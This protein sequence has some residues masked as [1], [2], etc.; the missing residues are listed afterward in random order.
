[1]EELNPRKVHFVGIGGVGMGSFATALRAA[2]FEVSGSDNALYE[3]MKSVLAK[4]NI[5]LLE[6]FQAENISKVDP[7]LV[8]IGNVVRKDN[9]E[10][11]AWIKKGTKFLSFPEA[12]RTFLIDDKRSI[13]CAGTHGKTT[14]TSWISFLLSGLGLNPSYLIGGVPNDLPSGCLITK[15]D[16]CVVEGD[17]YDS[18]FFDKGPKFLHYYPQIAVISSIEF[19]HADIY[20]D[21]A[22]VKSSFEKLVALLPGDGLF[23]ARYDDPVV[24][25]IIS[26]ALCPV[27]TFGHGSGAMWKLGAVEE[28]IHGFTF[29]IIYKNRSAGTFKTPL[30]GEHNLMNLIS[31]IVCAVNLGIPLEKVR[32]LVEKFTGAVRRQ[33]VLAMEPVRIVD[34]F[35]HHPTEVAATVKAVR[36]RFSTGKLWALFEPR[37]ATARR[38]V[39]QEEYAKA[40][41]GASEILLAS[42]YRSQDLNDAE[43]FSVDTLVSALKSQGK[44]AQCFENTD[45]I[46]DYVVKHKSPGD[47]VLVMSNGEFGKIQQKLVAALR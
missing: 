24:M 12:V 4:A 37:S 35:A 13:V 11:S 33:Q 38:N 42:P 22:H 40:F 41:E 39:H 10:A 16:I 32:P 15:S 19:D 28:D 30:F 34:D 9:P 43:R 25:E 46:V 18:A 6:G 23:V 3:P 2:G 29:E 44:S 17:E 36:R 31:G 8:V 21:L 47:T 26:L 5:T 7:D 20:K 27:Q 1:M 14:T 45:A